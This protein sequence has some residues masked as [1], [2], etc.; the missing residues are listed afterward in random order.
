MRLL[1]RILS[2]GFAQSLSADDVNNISERLKSAQLVL[3]DNVAEYHY[4]IYAE[5]LRGNST[6]R[7][8]DLMNVADF[9]TVML[10]FESATFIKMRA[11]RFI[12]SLRVEEYGALLRMLAPSKLDEGR[13]TEHLKEV[14]HGPD[15]AFALECQLFMYNREWRRT[16]L[17]ATFILPVN[18]DGQLI[19]ADD[20][21]F[22]IIGTL[23]IDG[24]DSMTRDQSSVVINMLSTYLYPCFLALSFMHC[25][26]VHVVTEHPPPKLSKKHEKKAGRPLLKYRVLQIDHMKEVLEREGHASAEGLKKA[27]HICR[28][29]FRRYGSDGRGLLFGK[30]AATVWVPMHA[31][32]N[33]ERGV[34]A[35]DY[36][37]K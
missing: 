25:R 12:D 33:I 32:G 23:H 19:P 7:I 22:P 8:A 24:S 4:S 29:H 5:Q 17:M 35:K 1:D 30:Y 15:V 14:F 16:R 6:L 18:V 10:P 21:G 11:R 9:P 34:V 20:G 13:L 36:E 2:E 26:N 3:I 31:R 37:V 27:L 28:G